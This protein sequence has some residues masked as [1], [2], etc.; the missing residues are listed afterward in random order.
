M[1]INELIKLNSEEI[2]NT[3]IHFAIWVKV[4]QE[5]LYEF[6]KGKFKEW[7][8]SQN[9]RNFEKDFILSLIYYKSNERLF[10]GIYKKISVKETKNWFEYTTKLLDIWTEFIG[11][12]VLNF[13]KEFRASYVYCEKY[14]NSIS[15]TELLRNKYTVEP[16]P[17][18][19]NIKIDFDFLKSI[20]LQE[21][22]SWK[23][24]LSSVK[25]VYL[26]ADKLTWKL[27]VWSAYWNEAY[28]NRWKN[29]SENW[30]WDNKELK[31]IIREKWESYANNF[32]FS[33]LEVKNM[34]T[35]DDEI[36][37]R[38][39]YRKEILLTRTYGYNIN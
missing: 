9:K 33:I 22:P 17:W 37:K 4:K 2:I 18:Y 39:S 25:W 10:G 3:K 32:Q 34:N 1:L 35:D 16:F 20:V 14:I 26:I 13:Q 38:E 5:P 24:A 11:K 31:N 30:H 6:Y 21:E 23:T 12:L 19:D 15:I 27:Y 36:I 8:E 29:Y 7:Q 28:W